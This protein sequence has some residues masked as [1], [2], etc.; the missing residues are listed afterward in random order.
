M[1][2]VDSGGH[3]AYQKLVTSQL[4]KYF[5]NRSLIPRRYQIIAERFYELDLS[6]VNS[7]MNDCYSHFGPRPRLP[8]DMFRSCLLMVELGIHRSPNGALTLRLTHS[9]Q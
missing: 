8:S 4:K 7:I 9:V 2:P 1:K 5:P 6:Q 3:A